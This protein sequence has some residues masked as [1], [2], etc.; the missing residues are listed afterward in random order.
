MN[1]LAKL[2]L[3]QLKN[4][5]KRTFW[6]VIAIVLATALLTCVCGLVASGY[7]MLT[8]FLGEDFG[9][10][11][12]AY[13]GLLLV[14]AVILGTI[15][16]LMAV[17]VISNVFRVS[18]ADRIAEFGMLKCVGATEV[19]IKR[20]IFYEGIYLSAVGVP[21]GL[22]SGILLTVGT[23]RLTNSYL[24]ELNALTNI[25]LSKLTFELHFVLSIP[26]LAAAALIAFLTVL[27]SAWI[28]ARKASAASAIENIKGISSEE[29][30]RSSKRKTIGDFFGAE[31]FLAGRNLSYNKK[32][33]RATVSALAIG[34]ILFTVV[35]SVA[36]QVKSM[37]N[38]MNS[39][40]EYSVT[41]DYQSARYQ[42]QIE[43]TENYRS[44]YP[45]PIDSRI[46]SEIT[47]E[48]RKYDQGD[49][50]GMGQEYDRYDVTLSKE[51]LTSEF[52]AAYDPENTGDLTLDV[53]LIVLDEQHYRALCEKYGIAAG[54][55]ILLN[56]ISINENGHEVDYVPFT[57]Q[58]T[59][60]ELKD[61]EGKVT[62]CPVDAVLYKEEIPTELFYPNTNPVRLIV[63][64][65]VIRG[66]NWMHT[67]EDQ[68]GYME[69]ATS[70]LDRYF[71]K[72][73]DA[74]YMEDGFT[75]RVYL[76][77]D[78]L[79]VMN[80]AVVL[81]LVLSYCFV[82]ILMLIGF[83][84]VISTL[85]AN[86][87]MRAR[88]FA[89]YVSIGMTERDLRRM[90]YLEGIL[91]V[92]KAVLIGVPVSIAAT[93]LINYPIKKMYPIP[94]ELPAASIGGYVLVVLLVT[95]V[96]TGL[97]SRKLRKKS[98]IEMIRVS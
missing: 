78:Y 30:K 17:V 39:F 22:L 69:Y 79:R 85:S 95:V 50:F 96:I 33:F 8:S 82:G 86:V 56:H 98:I 12:T 52:M 37:S 65:A 29:E 60:L 38:M 70:V 34:M 77:E 53:E 1:V 92:L 62:A 54:S 43:G 55:A 13:L 48:L 90:L 73:S 18:A 80:I 41:A 81:A 9:T 51:Q 57:E 75:T 24:G 11:R 15:I 14:P 32:N 27:I 44:V 83:T 25:M 23:I 97:A 36:T 58:L 31:G 40:D 89:V 67:S 28:P 3:S 61:Q 7:Q 10:Y 71:P 59:E 4:Y 66:Y 72:D 16:L 35:G 47:E 19:Q 5:K 21:I 68:E 87:L 63:D 6:A 94:Y 49:V 88:E 91:C 2:A 45:A 84:N 74:D 20:S 76:T 42:E 26:A 64:H 46:G 93:Y